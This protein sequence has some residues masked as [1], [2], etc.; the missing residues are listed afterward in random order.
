[1]SAQYYCK[2]AS[3]VRGELR[4]LNGDESGGRWNLITGTTRSRTRGGSPI[5]PVVMGAFMQV[6]G[7]VATAE[8]ETKENE[9]TEPVEEEEP[10]RKKKFVKPPNN[11]A[12][13]EVE[14]ISTLMAQLACRDCG[15]A[16]KV[17]F[18]NVCLAT[19]VGVQC[20][21]ESC[22]FIFHPQPPAATT[23]HIERGDN[24][25]RSTD[26]AL[27]VL[28]VLGF[29]SMGDGCTEAARLLGL[30]GLPNDTTMKSRSFTIIEDRVG[31][32]LRQLSDDLILENLIEEARLSMELSNS[33]DENDFRV[34]K[35]SLTDESIKLSTARMP[36]IDGSYDMAW[37]QKGSGHVYNSASGHGTLIGR[38]TR[39]VVGLV[40][41]SKVC[42]T[43]NAWNKKN[44]GIEMLPHTPCWKN[45]DGSSGS[46]EA[47][48]ILELVVNCFD[49]YK[50]IVRLLCCDDDSSIRADCQ[51]SNA[52]YLKNNNTDT[53]PQ[54]PKKVGKYKGQMQPRP[55]K[56]KLP[57]HVPEPRFVADPNH[58]RKG[59]LGELIKMDTSNVSAKFTMTRMDSTRLGTNFGYMARALKAKPQAE[60][61]TA[62]EAVL[63]HHFD[64]HETCGPWCPRRG[65]TEAQR[66]A[67]K[68]YY[69]CKERDA[70]LYTQLQE[71]MSRFISI[72]K[73]EEMAHDMDT[74][75]NEAFNNICTWFSPKNK[76]FAGSGSLN[77]R[78][79]LAVGINSIGVLPFYSRLF[80][81][82]GIVMTENVE[83]Y[84]RNK[85]VARINHIATGKTSLAK[86][87][88]NKL[89]YLK[90]KEHTRI[91]KI[92]FHKRAGTYR[93]GMNVD[94]PFGELLN[95]KEAVVT[96]GN[97]ATTTSGTNKRKN[98][99]AEFCE[100]CGKNSHLTK[101]HRLCDATPDA[102]KKFRKQDGSSLA[103]PQ[104]A[105]LVAA[106]T[107]HS[108]SDEERQECDLLDSL[109]WDTQFDSDD[110][111]SMAA[112]LLG[113]DDDVLAWDNDCDE[114]EDTTLILGTL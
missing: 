56:G 52:D 92:E 86:K 78:I 14:Q 61:I 76:V 30:I 41:K 97:A 51:W 43:C 49:K 5:E 55:D 107:G 26:Y 109:P 81:K 88:K 103:V 39:K 9:P 87:E 70:K 66:S 57:G 24:F 19:S 112:F 18:R 13:V 74:N 67:S 6:D 8:E 3:L 42:N 85:E 75:M 40:I 60:W 111:E 71:K 91:A 16:V 22:G 102:V 89:K 95:G 15:E 58:R 20:T 23:M 34:W 101:R 35:E 73:L 64:C 90:L 44:P 1:M 2:R 69:R 93:K 105:A 31:P 77:N 79:A 83:H 108:A 10:V 7:A 114:P 38:R 80:H 48:G 17:T 50:V 11:R 33:H 29:I 21:N 99:D 104:A 4:R 96:G 68:K 94:D 46:M 12:I 98:R 110:D 59:F 53:L 25:E 100:W 72:D 84:L 54:V 113:D 37:Q 45:H 82:L 28:Y 36:K 106:P 62:A 27:N 63:E 47:A 32:H 65:E